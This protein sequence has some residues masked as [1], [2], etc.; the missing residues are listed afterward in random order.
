MKKIILLIII[1]VITGCKSFDISGENKDKFEE[2]INSLS[3]NAL[4]D[5]YTIYGRYFNLSGEVPLEVDNL[6]LVLKNEE[7]E[8]EY[9]LITSIKD[10]KT[11]FKTNELI[12]EGINLET[13]KE[14]E[15]IFLL[16]TINSDK[17]SYYTLKNKTEYSNLEYYTIT[18]DSKNLKINIEFDNYQDK[19]FLYLKAHEE[20][21]PDD[22]YDI[23]IDAGHGG[24]D[25]GAHKNGYF[26]SKINLDYA[27]KLE[28]ELTKLGLKV[29]MTR[30]TDTSIPN[31]GEEGR[32]SIPYLT[33]A[34]LMLSIHMN[35]AVNNVGSGG[36]EIY[37]ANNSDTTFASNLAKNIVG[38]TSTNYSKN[39]FCKI[40]SGVYLRTL[41]KSDIKE[42]EEEAK[43]KGFTPYEK[44]T[45]RSTY[46]YIIRETGGIV[47]G[48]YVD[49]RNKEKEYNH[50]YNSNHGC[51]SYLLELGYMN[52]N[53]NLDILLK[54]KDSYIKGI[55]LSIKEY[56]NL[57]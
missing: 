11:I 22:V 50:Y 19:E 21:L 28:S 55:V 38:F 56:L 43:E 18:K 3:G 52:S 48:A 42:I 5:T 44:A 26:E 37:V 15:Y 8:T 20:K 36:V 34:K 23:V 49:S 1:L 10:N 47:T 7:F 41:S 25:V 14:G 32:V 31:Y 53:T 35:S 54:E 30:T 4:I 6:V 17:T 51:E 46:Y 2:I 24:V 33:K 9:N 45:T 16:K 39:T 13:I 29:K 27:K 12:N 57:I 40:D